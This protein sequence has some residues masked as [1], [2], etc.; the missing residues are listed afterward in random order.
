MGI[1]N[2]IWKTI[3]GYGGHYEVSTRG[4][5]RVKDRIIQKRTRHGGMMQQFYKG[6]HL[7]LSQGKWGHL[8]TTIGVGGKT[9]KLS[10]HRVVLETFVGACPEGMEACHNNGVANDN[11][12]EN[13]RWDTH[14]NN[15]QDRKKHGRYATCSDH[16]MAKFSK[17]LILDIR[18]GHVD[19][20]EAMAIGVSH[21]HFYRIRNCETWKSVE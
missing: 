15:N 3:P 12:I 6:R 18:S 17:S 19:K 4:R 1:S 8:Y 10:V 21:T 11:R 7:K 14:H 2:E 5:I 16:P 9:L 20:K 13:L